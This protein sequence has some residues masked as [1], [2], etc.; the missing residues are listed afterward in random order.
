MSDI[1]AEQRDVLYHG[2]NHGEQGRD[3]VKHR[4]FGPLHTDVDP[5]AFGVLAEGDIFDVNASLKITRVAR[6]VPGAAN[7]L[8]VWG[9]ITGTTR[10][11]YRALFDA[12]N[13]TT[14][15]PSDAAS[16][17]TGV[18]ASRVNHQHA[19]PATY[20]ATAHNLLSATHG[21]TVAQGASRGSVIIGDST[22]AWNELTV[23]AIHT[24]LIT[25]GTD[26]AWNT[27]PWVA[28]THDG[29][30]FT[31]ATGAWTVASGDQIT[32]AY[33]RIGKTMIV[34][35][36]ILASTT[37]LATASVSIRI[38]DSQTANRTI[39]NLCLVDENGTTTAAV[40]QVTA[41][42]TVIQIFKIPTANI[43]ALTDLIS[44][45]GEITFEVQ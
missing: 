25:D 40:A 35:F 5:G 1:E 24:H 6:S 33:R 28:V 23:G 19:S 27:M 39:S 9:F 37:S 30:A 42:G 32:F 21:D 38:P 29:A 2:L 31:A 26:V 10:G 22:P 7:L 13:P 18:I 14:I 43:A 20:P 36:R 11:A 44:V 12:T 17:G 34:A 41:A 45:I 15:A 4:L 16:P 3:P 8:S